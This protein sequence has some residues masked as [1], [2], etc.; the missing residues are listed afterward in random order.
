MSVKCSIYDNVIAAI[1]FYHCKTISS[2]FPLSFTGFEGI[3]IAGEEAKD[4]AKSIPIA[5]FTAMGV[6]T[7]LYI[8]ASASLTLMVPYD[9]VD[10]A[11]P[12]PHAFAAHGLM[13]VK[14][15]IA[16]GSLFGISTTLLGSLFSLP[17]AVYAMSADGLFF[18]CF[19]YINGW[20]QTPLLAILVF[21]SIA[22]VLTLL[23]DMETLVEF[24]SIGTLSSFTIVAAGVL[25]LRYQPAESCQFE[26]RPEELTQSEDKQQLISSSQSHEDIGKLRVNFTKIP[27]L[28]HLEGPWLPTI[29]IMMG[30]ISMALFSIL[31]V[32][33]SV[34]IHIYK[35]IIHHYGNQ[36]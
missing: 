24:L 10:V 27:L 6:V 8:A 32:L 12:F 13:W 26:L 31:L 20:T 9:Q 18:R 30:I 7:A 22:G 19:A 11:A 33:V 35:C 21:G 17:R 34:K 16:I 23:I 5:T 25:V 29:A 3:A 15:A 14:V 2:T 4:P 1:Q 28:K 36:S